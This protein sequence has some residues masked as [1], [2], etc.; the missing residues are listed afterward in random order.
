[1]YVQNFLLKAALAASSCVIMCAGKALKKL[2]TGHDFVTS[3]G[4]DRKKKERAED[5]KTILGV[6]VALVED[7]DG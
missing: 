3:A 1:M 7:S 4:K 5:D 6:T 2:N